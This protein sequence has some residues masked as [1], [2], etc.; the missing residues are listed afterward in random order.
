MRNESG[1]VLRRVAGGETI[2]VTNNGRPAAMIVPPPSDV[3]ALLA[4][5]GQLRSALADPAILPSIRRGTS[6][7]T[8]AE[9]LADVR[10]D[11]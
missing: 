5:Q 2:V 3:L 7:L 8:T 4:A 6:S 11:R 1:E 10:G 9:L